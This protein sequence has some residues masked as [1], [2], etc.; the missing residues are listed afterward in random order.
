MKRPQI[1][2]RSFYAKLV[3]MFLL[4][5]M[6]PFLFMGMMIYNVYSNTMYENILGNFS[7]TDQIMAKNISD[8]IAELS[9]DTEYIYKSSV[10]DY[11]Y[12]YELFED[13]EMSETGRNAMI[14]KVLRT[15]LYM[16]EAI[17]HV[18]FVTPDG[19][20]YSSMKAPELLINEYEMQD[21]YK[22]HYLAASRDVQIMPTHE[23]KY[24][25]NSE[26]NDFTIYRNIMNTSTIQKAGSEV[27]GT[28]FIDI[29]ADYLKKMLT[30]ESYGTNHEIYVVDS[31][32]GRYIY[33]S[34]KQYEGINAQNDGIL[35]DDMKNNEDGYLE[36]KKECLVYQKIDGTN[37]I[38]IDKVIPGTIESA[39]KMIRNTTILL[40]VVGVS[41]LSILYLYYSKKLNKPVQM[42]KETMSC[43]EKGDLDTR[44]HI[45]SNDE[46]QDIGNGMNQ[47]AENLSKYVQK[48][49]VAEIRQRDAELE[50]LKTQIQPH[51]L[52][53]TLDVMIV[54]TMIDS[55]SGQLKYLIGTT[56]KMVM[57]QQEIA[58]ISNYFKL[59]EVRYDS[60]FSLS[61]EIPKE[62]WKCRVPHLIIQPVVENAV[63][64][65]LRPNKGSGEVVVQAKQNMDFLE[66]TV[67]DNGVGMNKERLKEVQ[68]L[69]KS[70]DRVEKED[71]KGM[72][73]GVKNVSDRIKH[74]YGN[75]YGLEI[76][77]YE[78]MGTIVKYWLPLIWEDI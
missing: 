17:D 70:D 19:K 74:L 44:V 59:I 43:I 56:G 47:M 38:V 65:G 46:F 42:L 73:I 27:L 26:K 23:T 21:W 61:V 52:Y 77:A 12:F 63:K 69:L 31:V 48:A 15:I 14:T 60:R 45:H 72:S 24:Y 66:I 51:Y 50:A 30:Q 35:L 36:K 68:A 57:L 1:R 55:L 22:R 78:G 75:E 9:D 29:S 13:T 5:G 25:R 37:W 32:S 20:I 58:C 18:F 53:N 8:L 67:M 10:S 34:Q 6:I 76:D 39:Y 11:D 2:F 40:I 71:I 54:A 49:Y 41:L 64:H 7:M 62:L 28:L 4:M 16:N 33:H 3:I